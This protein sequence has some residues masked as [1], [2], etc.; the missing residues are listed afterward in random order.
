MNDRRQRQV[1]GLVLAGVG[2]ALLIAGCSRPEAAAVPTPPAA[3]PTQVMEDV[4]LFGATGPAQADAPLSDPAD[5]P[6]LEPAAPPL[7]SEPPPVVAR[8]LADL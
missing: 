6:W 2:L 1:R 5:P 7:R 4:R 3:E 8:R